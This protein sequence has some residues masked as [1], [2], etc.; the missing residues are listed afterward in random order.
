M[1]ITAGLAHGAKMGGPW[2]IPLAA[3]AVLWGGWK[4]ARAEGLSLTRTYLARF[5][6]LAVAGIASFAVSTPYAFI[7]SFYFQS[8]RK[9][10][11]FFTDGPLPPVS[12]RDWLMQIWQHEGTFL[13]V[14]TL[15][16]IAFAALRCMLT[17]D[18][19]WPIL[20]AT[21]FG[22]S[23]IIWYVTLTRLWVG[24]GYLLVALAISALLVGYLLGEAVRLLGKLGWAGRWVGV[25]IALTALGYVLQPRWPC[26]AVMALS[27]HCQSLTTTEEAGRWCRAN[28]PVDSK[29]LYDDMA[30]FDPRHFPNAL[31]HGG[32]MT[33]T[34]LERV[35]PDYFCL[36]S[37]I[38]MA[39]HYVEMRKTQHD[40]RGHESPYSVL[41]YQD[42]L[43]RGGAPEA[44]PLT[45]IAPTM[46]PCS[47]S[48][49]YAW[50]LARMVFGRDRFL[51][52]NE[53]R[54]YRYRRAE[55]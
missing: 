37:S 1:G 9:A 25:G 3:L 27:P 2:F 10:W 22:A 13:S 49:E 36:S 54:I 16:A 12:I 52:G 31:Q 32:L 29:I 11:A 21:V 26:L 42:L 47:T 23:V 18:K 46:P 33:Y 6:M 4:Y 24:V 14:A 28:V 34:A 43:D 38:Y 39:R 48:A 35:R 44:E 41:L 40:T 50:I 30:Y 19:P 53:I 45:T 8:S 15:A 51:Q 5:S 20:L 55:Q 7:D 17:R